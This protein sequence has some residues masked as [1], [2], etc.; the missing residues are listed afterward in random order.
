MGRSQDKIDFVVLWVDGNDPKW[1]A[2]KE[3]WEKKLG[4]A[5][6]KNAD[7][8]EIRYRDW[9][10]LKYWFRG[11]EQFAPWVNKIHFVTCGHV[12]EW[13]DTNHSKLHI[14]KHS[15]FMPKDA[16]PTF[17]SNAIEASLHKIDGLA[18]KFVL[19]N[20]DFFLIDET[21]PTDFFKDGKPANTFS[22]HPIMPSDGMAGICFNNVKI[23]NCNFK[24]R[25]SVKANL[26]KYLSPK[27]GK[28]ILKTVPLLGYNMFPGFATFHMPNSYLKS[29]WKEVWSKESDILNQT[30]HHKFRDYEKDTNHWLYNYWQFANGNFIQRNTKF[31]ANTSV[32]DP[33]L[34]KIISE[35]KAKCINIGDVSVDDYDSVKKEIVKAFERILPEK[36][37]YEIPRR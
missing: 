2:E 16:L 22:L 32:A 35:Q 18:E 36:S 5:S 10:F 24:F 12:P 4:I 6:D 37:S 20:D 9:G 26:A 1:R 28:Y 31:G 21:K 33:L 27:Q 15:D 7:N 25:K 29:T 13:L 14:V 11:V 30:L 17:N 23:I 34:P 19:F 8:S 3:K